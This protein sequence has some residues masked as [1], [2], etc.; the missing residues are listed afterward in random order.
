MTQRVRAGWLENAGFEPRLFESSLQYRLVKMMPAFFSADSVD[1]VTGCRKYPLPAPLF[2]GVRILAIE[3]VR[4]KFPS[5][6]VDRLPPRRHQTVQVVQIV[7]VVQTVEESNRSSCSNR[8]NWLRHFGSA[9]CARTAALWSTH[10]NEVQAVK[11]VQIVS[12]RS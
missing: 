5:Q 3:S 6:R 12:D 8:S 10:A 4:A 2:T 9:R 11:I 1:I 7:Q